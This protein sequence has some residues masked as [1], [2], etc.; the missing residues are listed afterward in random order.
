MG[1]KG[2][3]AGALILACL[4]MI[5]RVGYAVAGKNLYHA[6][7]DVDE[8]KV[9]VAEVRDASGNAGDMTEDIRAQLMNALKTR[10]T[11]NFVIQKDREDADLIIE[12]EVLER[13]WR[14]HD[15]LDTPSLGGLI[16]DAAIDEDYGRIQARFQLIKRGRDRIFRELHKRLRRK[17]VLFDKRLQATVDRMD[18]TEEQSKVVLERRIADIFMREAF[19][20]NAEVPG[21]RPHRSI[22]GM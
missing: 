19:S 13:I 18:M 10:M 12:C 6:L 17:K 20:K 1:R 8:V 21:A 11:I 15:P 7:E 14:D 5:S 3:I 9:Y 22:L 16:A 4:M 2:F